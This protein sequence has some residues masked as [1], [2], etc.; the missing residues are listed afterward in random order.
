MKIFTNQ[1]AVAA[2]KA[3][4]APLVVRGAHTAIAARQ[5]KMATSIQL[6]H[7]DDTAGAGDSDSDNEAD[8]NMS[9]TGGD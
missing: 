6:V 5:I 1:M 4:V 3:L 8:F 7:F 9:E 2:R